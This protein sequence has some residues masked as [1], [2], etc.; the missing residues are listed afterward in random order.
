MRCALSLI[1]AGIASAT[2]VADA[3]F[4]LIL[5]LICIVV[6]LFALLLIELVLIKRLKAAKLLR[7]LVVGLLLIFPGACWHL[8]WASDLIAER[9]PEILEGKT[10]Q[11]EGV[12]IG[13]PERSLIAQQFQFEIL[14]APSGFFPR[15]VVLNYYGGATA[16]PGQYWRFAVRLNRPH[17]FANPG[18][19]DYE[20]W[21]FQ[22]GIS[23][24]GY[25]RDAVSNKL[26]SAPSSRVGFSPSAWLHM[27]R[28]S[29]K[30]KLQRL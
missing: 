15:R 18:G 4:A 9:L 22:Q 12:V 19:F 28:F 1:C 27:L 10:L 7:R 11:V 8:N 5:S 14:H 23:A 21:L 29:L 3:S 16:V 20:A 17:G 30:I 6:L 2:F 25:V 26:I 13:L 24:R